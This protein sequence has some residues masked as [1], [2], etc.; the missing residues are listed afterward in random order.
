M[1]ASLAEIFGPRLLAIVLS[2]MGRDGAEGARAV[3]EAGGSVVV[4]DQASSVVW[5]MPGAVAALGL[6]DAVMPPE[7]IGRLA[8]ARCRP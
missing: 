5:G 7:A 1:F 4:Q 6:A 8:A 2:G 3:R